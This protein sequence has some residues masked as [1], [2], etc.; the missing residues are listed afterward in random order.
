MTS[1][2]YLDSPG[3][4]SPP[5]GAMAVQGDIAVAPGNS[6]FRDDGTGHWDPVGRITPLDYWSGSGR[7]SRPVYRDGVLLNTDKSGYHPSYVVAV[8][9][10][11]ERRWRV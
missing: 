2:I 11:A 8:C 3:N 6:Y 10:C 9:V 4:Y 1:S 7:G 5:T